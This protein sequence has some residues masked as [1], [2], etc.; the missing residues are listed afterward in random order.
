MKIFINVIIDILITDK[1]W[2]FTNHEYRPVLNVI[3]LMCRYAM[4]SNNQLYRLL[5]VKL[6]FLWN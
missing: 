3:S 5:F 4:E 2:V 6:K 1:H